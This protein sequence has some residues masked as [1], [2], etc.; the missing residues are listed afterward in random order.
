[1]A[2]MEVGKGWAMGDICNSANNTK[3]FK[4]IYPLISQRRLL[5]ALPDSQGEDWK[6]RHIL[7]S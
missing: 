7:C 4:K 2:W 5:P 6:K 1:M 3:M